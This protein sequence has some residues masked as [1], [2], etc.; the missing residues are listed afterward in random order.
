MRRWHLRVGHLKGVTSWWGETTAG[1]HLEG[2]TSQGGRYLGRDI[3]KDG[4]LV[5]GDTLRG[6][7]ISGGWHLSGGGT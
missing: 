6:D 3:W 5:V 1:W 2:V 4:T 7:D